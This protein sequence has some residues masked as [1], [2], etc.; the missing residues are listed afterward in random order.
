MFPENALSVR[1]FGN[2][3]IP[4]VDHVHLET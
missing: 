4:E 1:I 2:L 3:A